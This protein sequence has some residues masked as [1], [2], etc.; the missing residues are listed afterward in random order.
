MIGL[1]SFLVSEIWPELGMLPLV[2]CGTIAASMVMYH[3]IEV[4]RESPALWAILAA[5]AA[6]FL[7][8]KLAASLF[9]LTFIWHRYIRGDAG[10]NALRLIRNDG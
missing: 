4:S 5:T 1:L 2:G 6:F 10:M 3:A 7:M 9:D 8:W